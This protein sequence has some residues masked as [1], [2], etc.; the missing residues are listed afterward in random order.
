[1][2]PALRDRLRRS[3]L[4]KGAVTRLRGAL[5]YPELHTQEMG[6]WRLVPDPSETPRLT[7][8]IPSLARDQAF[9]G[10]TTGLEVF[11]QL[12]SAL[13]ATG[14]ADLR[15]LA[16]AHGGAGEAGD[17]NLFH[18]IARRAGLDPT[19]VEIVSPVRPGAQVATRAR[20]L[21]LGYNWVLALNLR[22]LVEAQDARFGGPKRPLWQL[23]QEY[24][25]AFHAMGSDHLLALQ[26]FN[27]DRPFNVIFN[28][29]EL[30]AF[31]R[32]QGNRV[33]LGLVIDPRLSGSMR[34][35]LAGALDPERG[36]S[37][38]AGRRRRIVVYGRPAVARNC[39]SLAAEGLRAWAARHPGQR[40]WEAVSAG[41][42]HPPLPLG[43]G[44]TLRALGKLSLE[45][46]AALL[47]ESA[48]GLS[49]MA[50]PHPSYP[51]LEMAH[52]GLRTLTNAYPGK[53]LSQAHDNIVSLRDVRPEALGDALAE[54]CAAFESDPGAGARG[55]SHL[56]RYLAE[57]PYPCIAEAA[58]AM[59]AVLRA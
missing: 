3:A 13:R 41:M 28:S 59:E 4:L 47:S 36:A 2:T 49:L 18:A 56:P 1:M 10:V 35:F 20:E 26:A 16:S 33:D 14:P 8:A 39:W 45:D 53:D 17:A 38:L 27:P 31:H 42:D 48:L 11:A 43:D 15:L 46:Y 37:P 22:P 40:D 21:F 52:F 55:A 25:P 51:P 9:G 12:G 32:A 6:A 24:E 19:A 5:A 57:G 44:R 34:P 23:I 30:E 58:A 50:S 7:L 54:A 29:R